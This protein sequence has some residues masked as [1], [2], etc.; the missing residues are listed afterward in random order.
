MCIRDSIILGSLEGKSPSSK[1]NDFISLL[2]SSKLS[3]KWSED[4]GKE[5]WIKLLINIAINPICAITGLRNGEILMQNDIWTQS[6]STMLEASIIAKASGIDIDDN[7]LISKLKLII[8][9][10]EKN[11]CSMLQD[12]MNGKETEI[13][14]LCGE[15]VSKGE[16]L[17]IQTPLNAMLCALI[18]GIE[19]SSK[20]P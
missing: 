2:E 6:Y 13:D 9:S 18:K 3:P 8:K 16:S 19:K 20:V 7:D 1:T 10:T 12:I 17:G 4:I 11:R 15:I 5:I 14:S